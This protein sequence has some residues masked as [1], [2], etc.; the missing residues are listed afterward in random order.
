[1]IPL[2]RTTGP[3][4]L[5]ACLLALAACAS[6]P[7]GPHRPRETQ[8]AVLAAFK[9]VDANGDE[10]LSREEFSAGF[11][12][13]VADFDDIDTDHNGLINFAELWSYIQWK[14]MESDPTA[15]PR[16]QRRGH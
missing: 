11:P 6:H 16:A 9:K 2:H 5:G 8:A 4:L 15:T 3:L 7:A 1:M 10:Q 13:D 14:Q 12:D